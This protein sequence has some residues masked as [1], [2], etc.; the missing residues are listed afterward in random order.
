MNIERKK[1]LP[2]FAVIDSLTEQNI[3]F[4][5]ALE[6]EGIRK[7]FDSL[8]YEQ[9]NDV[10]TRAKLARSKGFCNRHSAF[11]LNYGASLGTAILYRQQSALFDE[12]L[13]NLYSVPTKLLKLPQAVNWRKHKN[14]PAC[15][16]QLEDRKRYSEI[17][18][19][20]LKHSDSDM[21]SAFENSAPLCVPH[22]LNLLDQIKRNHKLQQYLIDIE[23][24][25]IQELI[26]DLDEF[27]RKYDYRYASEPV[28]KER[29]CCQRAVRILS[30]Y[31]GI[32]CK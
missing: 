1:H 18:L 29:D 17:F 14:C 8:L 15:K 30:G 10:A 4:L 6:L 26:S 31:E 28:G 27:I 20:A 7:Y 23:R 2:Y 25:K 24:K 11:I 13:D 19:N 21:I 16:H 3:C 22:F 32:F 5:C 12:L 9:V